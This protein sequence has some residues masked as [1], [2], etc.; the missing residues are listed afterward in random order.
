LAV[1]QIIRA[2]GKGPRSRHTCSHQNRSHSFV[3]RILTATALRRA[4]I[5]TLDRA[6]RHAGVGAAIYSAVSR[7][8]R[9]WLQPG[10]VD[11]SQSP[12]LGL[13]LIWLHKEVPSVAI[14][15]R[16]SSMPALYRFAV[17]TRGITPPAKSRATVR[18]L[19]LSPRVCAAARPVSAPP[20]SPLA[21][22]RSCHLARL[23][24]VPT[25]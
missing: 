20:Q 2:K 24:P 22:S 11:F 5:R 10:P 7:W 12:E 15:L 14:A 9:R 19:V 4:S 21:S 13:S 8:S 17:G 6:H 18:R 25:A 23:A 3:D 16:H 1:L